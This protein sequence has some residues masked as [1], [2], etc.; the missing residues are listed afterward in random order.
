MD[1][2]ITNFVVATVRCAARMPHRGV[3]TEREP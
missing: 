1:R 3:T 2:Q